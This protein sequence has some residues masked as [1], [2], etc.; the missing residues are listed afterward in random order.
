VLNYALHNPYC[1]ALFRCHC[2]W[3]WAGGSSRC[4]IHHSSGP[5]CPWCNVRNTGLAKLAFAITDTFTV[6]MMILSYCLVMAWQGRPWRV[7]RAQGGY[8][9]AIPGRHRAIRSLAPVLTFIILGFAMGLAFYMGTDYP[10]F[11]WITDNATECGWRSGTF[12]ASSLPSLSN[13]KQVVGR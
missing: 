4:N 3:P 8:A 13:S 2:T 10:C 12:N 7:D 11:L 9:K 6:S 1:G 5:R